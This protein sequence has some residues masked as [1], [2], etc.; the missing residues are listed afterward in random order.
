MERTCVCIQHPTLASS[1]APLQSE[2]SCIKPY[3][4]AVKPMLR[5]SQLGQMGPLHCCPWPGPE[6]GNHQGI[7]DKPAAL[8]DSV[9]A[10]LLHD[11]ILLYTKPHCNRTAVCTMQ[12]TESSLTVLI[13]SRLYCIFFSAYMLKFCV[14]ILILAAEE[15]KST[16]AGEKW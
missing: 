8:A 10:P 2:R 12:S 13:M 15:I 11:V 7:T 14:H 16:A 3:L 6:S 9:E 5:V 4:C 1:S